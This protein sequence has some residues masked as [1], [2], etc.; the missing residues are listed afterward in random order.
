MH[1]NPFCPL[2]LPSLPSVAPSRPF[3][4]L[5]KLYY[6]HCLFTSLPILYPSAQDLRQ[7]SGFCCVSPFLSRRIKI[8]SR[9][10]ISSEIFAFRLTSIPTYFATRLKFYG[11]YRSTSYLLR[12][13]TKTSNK[14]YNYFYYLFISHENLIQFTSLKVL[15]HRIFVMRKQHYLYTLKYLMYCKINSVTSTKNIYTDYI[16]LKVRHIKS[17]PQILLFRASPVA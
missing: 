10:A 6:F 2:L 15:F 11:I 13:A 4:I 16:A 9:N 5:C 7:L 1:R 12:C 8:I 14:F 3:L 17:F